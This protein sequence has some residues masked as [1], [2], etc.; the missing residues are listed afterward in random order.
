MIFKKEKWLVDA[1]EHK[2]KGILSQMDIDNAIATWVD[3]YNGKTMEEIP[4]TD[5]DIFNRKWF[6]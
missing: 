3:F 5:R 2:A 4:E 1:N 6:E